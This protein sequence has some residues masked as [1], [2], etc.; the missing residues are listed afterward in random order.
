MHK[1]LNCRCSNCYFFH[2]YTCKEYLTQIIKNKN[3]TFVKIKNWNV[4][5]AQIKNS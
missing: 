5:N 2:H 3:L 4:L 1:K